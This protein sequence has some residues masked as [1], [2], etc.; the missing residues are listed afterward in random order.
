LTI[1]LRD[2]TFPNS[3]IARLGKLADFMG[4]YRQSIPTSSLR[5]SKLVKEIASRRLATLAPARFAMNCH[6]ML[7]HFKIQKSSA[8]VTEWCA[9]KICQAVAPCAVPGAGFTRESPPRTAAGADI[10]TTFECT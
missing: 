5:V 7:A 2:K 9:L 4:L 1:A 3:R 10:L 6:E 8:G